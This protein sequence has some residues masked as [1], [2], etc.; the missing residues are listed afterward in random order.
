MFTAATTTDTTRAP[1]YKPREAYPGSNL[2]AA[3]SLTTDQPLRRVLSPEPA[4]AA[5]NRRCRARS[6]S[7]RLRAYQ[8]LGYGVDC[9]TRGFGSRVGALGRRPCDDHLVFRGF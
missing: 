6:P 5:T 8:S 4:N 9:R 1:A 3:P 2:P 7:S